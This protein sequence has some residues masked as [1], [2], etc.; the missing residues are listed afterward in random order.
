MAITGLSAEELE[1][2]TPEE[3][4]EW[5]ALDPDTT[6]EALAEL[7]G[8]D[9]DGGDEGDDE[10]GDDDGAGADDD[11]QSGNDDGTAGNDDDIAGKGEGEDKGGDDKTALL[12]DDELPTVNFVPRFSGELLP[13]YQGQIAEL[14]EKYEAGDLS[15][16]EM[17]AETRKLEAASRN[18][19][20][21]EQLWEAE[22]KAFFQHNPNFD[23]GKNR[24]LAGALNQEVIR[25]ANSKEAAGLSGIQILYAA[26]KSVSEALGLSTVASKSD[27]DNGKQGKSQEKPKPKASR[28]DIKT[29]GG[30]AS[31]DEDADTGTG[32]F[33]HLEKLEG[34]ALEAAVAKLTPAEQ[35]EWLKAS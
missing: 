17:L 8:D 24:I 32:K 3:R 5:E 28:P 20:T 35:A 11:D 19:E 4:A 1:R 21:Q 15:L 18:Q 16:T 10:G 7:A 6:D 25:L 30:V 9:D 26:K 22:Q 29:L 27:A 13:E 33:A 14:T 2:L 12:A 31:A 23:P 34:L